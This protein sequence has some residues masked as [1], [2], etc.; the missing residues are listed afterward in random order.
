M[1]H[2]GQAIVTVMALVNPVICGAIFSGLVA[3]RPFS[4]A[5]SNASRAMLAVAIILC[6]A[7]VFGIKLLHVFGI[8]LDVFRA[9]G[10]FVLM[11]MGFR[12]LSGAGSLPASAAAPDTGAVTPD[13]DAQQN[14][15]M[16][17][18]ILFAASPGT[19]TGVITVAVHQSRNDFP[20]T[21]LVAIAVAVVATW[22]IMLLSAR[23]GGGKKQGSLH[24]LTTRFMGLIVLAMGMQ[25]L[26][27]GVKAFFG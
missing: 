11:W 26:L 3:G 13:P 19:I 16:S 14:P 17:S 27:S 4:S 10:G 18:L 5:V 1:Q 23:A 21:T 22:V 20:V 15:S 25:F 2:Y 24:D 8:S 9:A 7:A 12:M 6:L